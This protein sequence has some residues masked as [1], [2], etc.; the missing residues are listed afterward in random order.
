MKI[1]AHG[2]SDIGRSRS[3]NEDCFFIAPDSRLFIVADGMGGH[4][5]GEVASRLAVAAARSYLAHQDNPGLPHLAQAVLAA[6]RAV[7]DNARQHPRRQG[8]GTTLTL[9]AIQDRQARLAHVGDSR[10]YL[11]R[12]SSLRQLS[13]DHTL[14]AHRDRPG[15]TAMGGSFSNLGHILIQAVGL[16]DHLQICLKQFALKEKDRLLLCSDGLSDMLSDSEMAAALAEKIPR[17][18]CS[19]LL[20]AALTAGGKDNITAVVIAVGGEEGSGAAA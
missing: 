6:N 18:A 5:A 14:A 19:D 10:L 3:N 4:P 2:V 8:M 12:A 7:R 20:S 13:E 11:L 9:L 1:Y 17:Q 15:G 16:N